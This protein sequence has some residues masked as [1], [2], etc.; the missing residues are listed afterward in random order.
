MLLKVEGEMNPNLASSDESELRLSRHSA[1][2]KE[3]TRYNFCMAMIAVPNRNGIREEWFVWAHG[4]KG[5][6][7][8][9]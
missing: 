9:W 3:G 8:S 4:F 1:D 6:H 7:S 5:L 2:G